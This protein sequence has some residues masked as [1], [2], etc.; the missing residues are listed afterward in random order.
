MILDMCVQLKLPADKVADIKLVILS[1]MQIDF[2][3]N[4]EIDETMWGKIER[5][6][7]EAG[8]K[9]VGEPYKPGHIVFWNL[10]H[11][12]GFPTL[13]TTPNTTMFAGFSPVLLNEFVN[14]GVEYLMKQTPWDMLVES[15]DNERYDV[16][17]F[18]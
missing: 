7:A 4:E 15:L 2:C 8:M 14:K 10:R 11:T 18:E 13:S 9:A 12:K 5:M 17:Y 6:Y 16:T 3:G 1:D